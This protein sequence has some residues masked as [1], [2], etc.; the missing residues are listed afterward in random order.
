MQMV[1]ILPYLMPRGAPAD[2]EAL[3]ELR[4]ARSRAIKASVAIVRPNPAFANATAPSGIGFRHG[5]WGYLFEP[6]VAIR[7]PVKRQFPG[8]PLRTMADALDRFQFELEQDVAKVLTEYARQQPTV[9]AVFDLGARTYNASLATT[10]ARS[11]A[12]SSSLRVLEEHVPGFDAADVFAFEL[13]QQYIASFDP[14][15]DR[16]RARGA[17][18][19]FRLFAAA[20]WA[21]ADG[22][23]MGGS[24]SMKS[25]A[26]GCAHKAGDCACF[27][28]QDIPAMLERYP[29]RSVVLKMDIEGAEWVLVKSIIDRGVADRIA[30]L[31]LECH[32]PRST[33]GVPARAH[34]KEN[35]FEY[36]DVARGQIALPV[37]MQVQW[38]QSVSGLG[39]ECYLLHDMLRSHG[40]ATYEWP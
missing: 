4:K 12:Y 28:S 23:V 3:R 25:T 15:V 26:D 9:K 14:F 18:G 20:A 2:A 40:I 29:P 16:R 35:W 32:G 34:G 39:A 8:A 21:N 36:P 30:I 22:I 19:A 6:R 13:D 33:S 37:L 5:P 31:F 27:P 17:T 10:E 1:D 7:T 38:W 11:S 24:S